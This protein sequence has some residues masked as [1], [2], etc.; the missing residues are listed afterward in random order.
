VLFLG[1]GG[2]DL[3]SSRWSAVPIASERFQIPE[4]DSPKN[5]YPRFVRQKEFDYSLYAF[6]PPS[7]TPP[8]PALDLGINDDLNV[9]RFHAKEE[10]GG[11]TYRWSQR[12]STIILDRIPPDAR[13]IALW[14]SNG[15]RPAAAAPA[16]VTVLLN[17]APLGTVHV[18]NGFREYTVDIPP[19]VAAAAATGEP[20][21][22]MLRVPTWNPMRVLGTNDDRDLGVMVDR[23]AVR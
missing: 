9:N 7:G 19:A 16:D 14:M 18:E 17:D 4:Y 15:G 3:L 1:G 20:V 6:T 2:T 5:A 22:I 10:A 13:T 21:R 12:Q 23:V 11:R 8:Q